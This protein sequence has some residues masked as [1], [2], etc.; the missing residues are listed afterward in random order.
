[1]KLV[2]ALLCVSAANFM[3]RFLIALIRDGESL[4]GRPLNR[5]L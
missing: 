5:A 3:L 2:F 4:P 1:M